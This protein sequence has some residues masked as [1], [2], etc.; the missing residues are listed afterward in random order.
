MTTKDLPVVSTPFVAGSAFSALAERHDRGLSEDEVRKSLYHKAT[1]SAIV[2]SLDVSKRCSILD[3]GGGNG[4]WTVRLACSGH[5]V[6]YVDV[7]EGMARKA[8]ANLSNSGAEAKIIVGDAHNLDFLPS[9]YFDIALAVGDLLCYSKA[10]EKICY[11]AFKRCKP[12]G[13]M[14][15]AVMGRFGVL[16]HLVDT[17]SVEEV[18]EYIHSGWWIEFTQNEL[19]N[20]IEAPL[21]AH[22]Y[23]LDELRQLCCSAGW[24]INSFFGAGIL[25]TL[26]GR[27][28]LMRLIEVEGIEKI[29]DLEKELAKNPALLECAMEFGVIAE[30]V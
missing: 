13:K 20:G 16:R 14:V 21:V 28:S 6:V 30:K 22:T 3:I 15:I 10:P 26:I 24:Q 19:G 12:G 4:I 8:Y 5:K 11:Q 17:L 18:K 7:A 1:W 23:T 9:N 27:E 25:R 2:Q 29:V